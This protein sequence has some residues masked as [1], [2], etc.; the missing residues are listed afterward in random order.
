[1]VVTRRLNHECLY[2]LLRA[3]NYWDFPKGNVEPG[4]DPFEAACREVEE[5]TSLANLSFPWGEVFCETEPYAAGKVARYYLAAVSESEVTLPISA[6]L[7]RP[8]H[9]EYRWLGYGKARA[10][11]STRLIAILEWAREVSG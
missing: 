10:V 2:L 11:L 1:M 4:E 6:E 3:Y 9:D 7:G 5:E 8:E